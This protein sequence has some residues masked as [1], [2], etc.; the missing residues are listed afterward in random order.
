[1][2]GA[3]RPRLT[4]H[5]LKTWPEVFNALMSRAK[6]HDIR[7]NDRDFRVGDELLLREWNPETETYT[8]RYIMAEITYITPGG[9]WGI[10]EN[11]CVMSLEIKYFDVG[12][13]A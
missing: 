11:L 12:G 4:Q 2:Q 13:A 7:V 9:E 3:A 5:D 1:M 10:P 8:F 6:K